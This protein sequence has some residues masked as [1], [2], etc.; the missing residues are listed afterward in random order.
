MTWLCSLCRTAEAVCV[1][2]ST[3]L[4][5]SCARPAAKIWLRAAQAIDQQY[6]AEEDDLAPDDM[7]ISMCSCVTGADL[8]G[9]GDD[10]IDELDVMYNGA[11]ATP[12]L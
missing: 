1:V 12:Y 3:T 8:G 7:G 5:G 9:A 10:K 6:R 11:A 2:D 4:C